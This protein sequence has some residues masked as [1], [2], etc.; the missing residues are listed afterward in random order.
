MDDEP[1]PE[2]LDGVRAH[3]DAVAAELRTLLGDEAGLAGTVVLDQAAM[4]RVSRVDALQ[5]QQMAK[6]AH[7][8]AA[9]RLDRVEAAISRFDADPEDY[10]WCPECGETIGLGRLRAVPESVFCVA[11]LEARGR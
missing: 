6:A 2:Q 4:G 8:R 1:S 9:M 3:L 7:R 10:A 11:C 5:A